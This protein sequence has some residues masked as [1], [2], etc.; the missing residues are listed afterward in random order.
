VL[1]GGGSEYVSGSTKQS[2]KDFADVVS[3]GGVEVSGE[4]LFRF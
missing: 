1:A 2:L 3:L 4:M